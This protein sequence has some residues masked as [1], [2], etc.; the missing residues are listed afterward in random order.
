LSYKTKFEARYSKNYR[1]NAF[2]CI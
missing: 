1:W 2:I